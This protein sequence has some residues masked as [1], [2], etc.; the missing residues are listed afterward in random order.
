MK[1]RQINKAT[2]ETIF[3]TECDGIDLNQTKDGGAFIAIFKK[4][5][6]KVKIINIDLTK[7]WFMLY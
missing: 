3:R 2:G 6:N 4:D 5:E 7:E 1:F